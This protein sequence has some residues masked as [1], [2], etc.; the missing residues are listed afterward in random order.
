M[1]Q[2][3]IFRGTS[4]A[5]KEPRVERPFWSHLR[6]PPVPM[7]ALDPVGQGEPGPALPTAS[8]TE[9]LRAKA[10]RIF[11]AHLLATRENHPTSCGSAVERLGSSW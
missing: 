6:T 11:S 10:N 2:S 5:S 3:I 8:W 7:A 4:L 9:E 1:A